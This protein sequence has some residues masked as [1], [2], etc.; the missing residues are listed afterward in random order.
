[1][2]IVFSGSPVANV[3]LSD[4]FNT[5]RVVTN[6]TLRD[7]ASTSGNNVFAGTQTFSNSVTISGTLSVTG[8]GTTLSGNNITANTITVTTAI[9]TTL[10][11]SSNR[12]LT[13]RDEAN[14][15]VWGS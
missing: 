14:N 4:S 9:V 3:E 1:M 15:V 12:T 6:K 5:W 7:A 10:Q 13:I 11:D 2:T 8:G